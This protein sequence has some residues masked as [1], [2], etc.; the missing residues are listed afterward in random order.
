MTNLA[1]ELVCE[2]AI[3]LNGVRF[4]VRGESLDGF[5]AEVCL[6]DFFRCIVKDT[7]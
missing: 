7:S 2:S 6:E 1:L 5:P 3:G 4:N